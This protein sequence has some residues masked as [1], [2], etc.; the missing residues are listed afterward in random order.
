MVYKEK[1]PQKQVKFSSCVQVVATPEWITP[2]AVKVTLVLD[3]TASQSR[4]RKELSKL[5]SQIGAPYRDIDAR[6][7]DAV[8]KVNAGAS[9]KRASIEIF[10]TPDRAE[11]IR[12]WRNRLAHRQ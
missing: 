4:L 7:V 11:T 3:A 5:P 1:Q 9:F 8:E 10:G 12:Y 2:T 6:I